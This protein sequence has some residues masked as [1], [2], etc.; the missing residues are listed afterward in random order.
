MVEALQCVLWQVLHPQQA[1]GLW[2]GGAIH[3]GDALEGSQGHQCYTH[4]FSKNDDVSQFLSTDLTTSHKFK[5]SS[6]TL[7]CIFT[8]FKLTLSLCHDAIGSI[9]SVSSELLNT[10]EWNHMLEMF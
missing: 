10:G 8:H 7:S 5:M 4:F 6:L 3:Q 9:V 2:T 1:D